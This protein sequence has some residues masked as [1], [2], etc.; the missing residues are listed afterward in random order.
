[1]ALDKDP[2]LCT[3]LPGFLLLRMVAL[4]FS[5]AIILVVVLR[6]AGSDDDD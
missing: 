6:A 5:V 3:T 2:L 1:M 4:V